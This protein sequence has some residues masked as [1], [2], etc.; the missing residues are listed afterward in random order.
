[1]RQFEWSRLAGLCV[2]ACT[3]SLAQAAELGEP[4][5]R[6][7]QA[8]PLVAD[9]ELTSLADPAAPVGPDRA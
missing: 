6:T 5:V 8:Q 3:L 9:V 2:L 4:V 1:M 7:Y